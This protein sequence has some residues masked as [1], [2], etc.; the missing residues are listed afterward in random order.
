MSD[1]IGHN[2]PL[3]EVVCGGCKHYLADLECLAFDNIPKEILNGTVKH[4]KPIEGQ[5]GDYIY[6]PE[7]E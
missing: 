3:Y 4:D 5:K 1:I 6:E 7:G 2:E